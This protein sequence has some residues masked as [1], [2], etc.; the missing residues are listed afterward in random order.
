MDILGEILIISWWSKSKI[1]SS[2][3]GVFSLNGI[4]HC[5]FP[6]HTITCIC[7]CCYCR[8][9][10]VFVVVAASCAYALHLWA[11]PVQWYTMTWLN[12]MI[13]HLRSI[14][15][16]YRNHTDTGAGTVDIYS[17]FK[18]LSWTRLTYSWTLLYYIVEK[19]CQ[20]LSASS[21]TVPS[22]W[23]APLQALSYSSLCTSSTSTENSL[24]YL[25]QRDQIHWKGELS[26]C[27]CAKQRKIS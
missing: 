3:G 20:F 10:I 16:P 14:R 25:H 9:V 8:L 21:Y 7:M 19:L 13:F 15:V 22:R 4:A 18:T 1:E 26:D 24:T 17:V 5:R 27:I 12:Q 23:L 2:V 6:L 11:W